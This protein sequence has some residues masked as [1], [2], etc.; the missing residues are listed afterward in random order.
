MDF[1]NT[2][3]LLGNLGEFIGSIGVVATLIYLAIQ[4]RHNTEATNRTAF[5]DLVNAQAEINNLATTRETATLL[6]HAIDHPFEDLDRIDQTRIVNTFSRILAHLYN[7]H[8]QW[9]GGF[10][11]DTQWR[12]LSAVAH[13]LFVHQ[14]FTEVW[15]KLLRDRYSPEFQAWMNEMMS[16]APTNPWPDYL[17]DSTSNPSDT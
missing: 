11:T 12:Q 5:Q 3:Q 10:I 16:S 7:A 14:S 6:V 15:N 1:A 17:S 2:A 9:I 13:G 8:S 4:I